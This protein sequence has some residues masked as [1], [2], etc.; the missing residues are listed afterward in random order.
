MGNLREERILKSGSAPFFLS[1]PAIAAGGFQDYDPERTPALVNAIK[2]LPL[3]FAEITN[4]DTVPVYL[5]INQVDKFY[6]PASTIKAIKDKNIW[7]VS[8]Q[9]AGASTS[10]ADKIKFVLQRQPITVDT[11]LRR[12]QLGG[13]RLL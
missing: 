4:D 11:Y 1:L 5:I 10:T 8:V 9:N 3:D 2:Y 6:V 13:R 7:R 12:Y